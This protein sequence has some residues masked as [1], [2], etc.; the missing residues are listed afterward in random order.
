ME[1]KETIYKVKKYREEVT[2]IPSE[3]FSV[4]KDGVMVYEKDYAVITFH[5]SEYIQ[6]YEQTKTKLNEAFT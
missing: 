5:I 3:I 4:W 1:A 6:E 2:N